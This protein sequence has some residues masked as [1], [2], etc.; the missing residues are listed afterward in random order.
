MEARRNFSSCRLNQG[1]HKKA[2]ALRNASAIWRKSKIK[3]EEK[4]D[5]K[6]L[7]CPL[8][9]QKQTC[10]VQLMSALGPTADFDRLSSDL[11]GTFRAAS[12]VMLPDRRGL[13][14]PIWVQAELRKR[15]QTNYIG[16]AAGDAGVSRICRNDTYF[17]E[18]ICAH[19]R[20]SDVTKRICFYVR[21]SIRAG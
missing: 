12:N 16:N 8:Y 20:R 7:T 21:E 13:G 2:G 4:Q 6:H 10:G 18:L 5:E 17:P 1:P 15:A 14:E 11:S 3:T 19:S 9:L